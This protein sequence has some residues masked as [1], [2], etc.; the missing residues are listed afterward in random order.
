[1]RIESVDV[2]G[3]VQAAGGRTH[4]MLVTAKGNV[5]ACG[6]GPLNQMGLG[7]QTTALKL[8]CLTG[9]DNFGGCGVRMTACGDNHTIIVDLQ[10]KIWVCGSGIHTTFGFKC[11]LR[12]AN[13]DTRHQYVSKPQ[14]YVCICRV[15]PLGCGDA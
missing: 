5:W 1:V 7:A 9:V 8:T 12:C 13:P 3:V 10:D 11:F 2:S 14:R 6:G 15:H 4:T